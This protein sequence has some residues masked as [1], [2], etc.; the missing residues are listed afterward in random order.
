MALPTRIFRSFVFSFGAAFAC[1]VVFMLITALFG[2]R[3]L[4]SP[5]IARIVFTASFLGSIA[6]FVL[7][8]LYRNWRRNQERAAVKS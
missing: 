5:D 3:E 1:V 2:V 8:A 4:L 7:R 6:F